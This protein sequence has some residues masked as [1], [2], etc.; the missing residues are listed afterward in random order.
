MPTDTAVA[1]QALTRIGHTRLLQSTDDPGPEAATVRAHLTDMADAVLEDFPWPFATRTVALPL[2]AAARNGWEYAYSVPAD[3]LYAQALDVE[4]TRPDALTA[5]TRVPYTIEA[6][7]AADGLVLLTDAEDAVLR[8][9]AR[10]PLGVF[11]AQAADA[12]AWRLASELALALPKDV[13][14]ARA[15]LAMYESALA[16]AHTSQLR[17]GQDAPPPLPRSISSR[18]G[19]NRL[20]WPR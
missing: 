13:N 4:G 18:G 17:Q 10:V 14:K 8:Y 6:N 11:S 19:R 2:L 3:F 16:R 12:L 1:N 9:T 7:D 5:A 20:P 15:M